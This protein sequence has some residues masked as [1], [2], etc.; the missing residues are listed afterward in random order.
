M[1]LTTN[2][3][4]KKP[5]ASDIVNIDDFNYNADAIDSAIKEVKT[6][7]D[8]LNLTATNVKMSDGS[9]VEDTVLA[10]KTSILNNANLINNYK[11]R[12]NDGEIW[13]KDFKYIVQNYESGV[14]YLFS[15]YGFPYG[16]GGLQIIKYT[17]SVGCVIYHNLEFG[18]DNWGTYVNYFK[19]RGNVSKGWQRLT[20]TSAFSVL[21]EQ[22]ATIQEETQNKI[23]IL[24]SENKEL[25]EEL[26]QIQTSIASLTSLMATTLEEK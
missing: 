6:K 1:K 9:T 22:V 4:L 3:G 8:S 14:Y 26:T 13:E 21:E 7:V 2:Y 18:V 16:W 5:G 17:E 25:R 11:S 15:C 20:S 12:R 10:N 23:S 24:E 19:D